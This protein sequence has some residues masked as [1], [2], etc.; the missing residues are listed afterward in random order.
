MGGDTEVSDDV[1]GGE[2]TTNSIILEDSPF[3]ERVS[4]NDVFVDP[5]GTSMHDIKWIAQRIRRP[6][7]DVKQD[8]R[9]NKT[10]REQ[11]KV[12]AVSRYA[13]DPSR[14]KI[15]DKNVGYAE[16]WEYYDIAA[17]TMCIFAEHS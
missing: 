4:P 13:D 6:I 17:N 7:G 10:A 14:K 3:A 12:M 16:I 11:V 15:Y 2:S 1:S 8:K 9:Y 5:D